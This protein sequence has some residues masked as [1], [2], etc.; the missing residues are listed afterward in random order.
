MTR[1]SQS[2]CAEANTVAVHHPRQTPDRDTLESSKLVSTAGAPAKGVNWQDHGSD[3][4]GL[5]ENSPETA[6]TVATDV[7]VAFSQDALSERQMDLEYFF[8]ADAPKKLKTIETLSPQGDGLSLLAEIL[9]VEKDSAIRIAALDRLKQE[10]NY[11]AIT[12]LIAALDDP[13]SEVSLAALNT[14]VTNGDRSLLPRL[15]KKLV[16]LPSGAT[17][18]Q[19]AQSIHQ[20]EYSVTMLMDGPT[21]D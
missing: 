3:A 11:A 6:A 4:H 13:V 9:R 15:K 5:S 18:N 10:Q 21:Y 2:V 19:Y 16:A 1:N 17:R 14:L 12:L 8:Q 20:L 7:P